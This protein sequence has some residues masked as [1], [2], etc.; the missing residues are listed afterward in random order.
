MHDFA[1]IKWPEADF[2]RIPRA[3]FTDQDVFDLEQER[4]FQ[5][6]VWLF[7]G[8]TAEIPNPGDFYT[9]YAGITPIVINRADD[10]SIH[11]FVNRCAH[12]SAMEVRNPRGNHT[13]HTCVYHV[14]LDIRNIAFLRTDVL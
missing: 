13:E 11:G 3:V 10:G 2:S 1:D 7:L 5:G 8:L 4:I 12:R 9:N 14:V 6:P